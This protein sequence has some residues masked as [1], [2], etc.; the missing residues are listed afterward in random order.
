MEEA[1]KSISTT[2]KSRIPGAPRRSEGTDSLLG[3][4][5]GAT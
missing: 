1:G 3:R 4:S 5:F 2:R